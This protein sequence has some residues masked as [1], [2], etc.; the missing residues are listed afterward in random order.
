V[1]PEL[2]PPD[3]SLGA[4]LVSIRIMFVKE[5]CTVLLC[6]KPHL[7]LL[8]LELLLLDLGGELLRSLRRH[9]GISVGWKGQ[10]GG[11][12][13]KTLEQTSTKGMDRF[14]LLQ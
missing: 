11:G 12:V 7:G 1:A 4:T 8:L 10:S 5:I 2:V 6:E 14:V 9:L 3:P 13:A